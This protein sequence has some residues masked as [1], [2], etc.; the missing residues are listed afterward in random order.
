MQITDDVLALTVNDAVRIA[1]SS[2]TVLYEQMQAGKLPF[3]KC[4][5]RTFIMRADLEAWLEQMPKLCG[6]NV[7][8]A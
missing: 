2:R 5:R 3:R 6:R 1:R 8:A 4:G 7:E